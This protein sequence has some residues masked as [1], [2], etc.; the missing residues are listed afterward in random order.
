MIR[1]QTDVSKP[2]LESCL[3][4]LLAVQP[5]ATFLTS[6]CFTF[7]IYD[8]EILTLPTSQGCHED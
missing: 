5:W 4:H 6:L 1:A 8:M 3:G 2:G 7:L